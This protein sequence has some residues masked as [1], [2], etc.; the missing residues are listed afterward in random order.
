MAI[1]NIPNQ[2]IQL[3]VSPYE[4]CEDELLH[5]ALYR[6]SDGEIYAQYK[7]IP[8]ETGLVNDGTYDFNA[9]WSLAYNVAGNPV[10]THTIGAAGY[11]R[12]VFNYGAL[13]DYYKLTIRVY[14]STQGSLDITFPPYLA[15]TITT[16]GN[17]IYTMYWDYVS[18]FSP[19]DYFEILPTTDFDG[20]VEIMELDAYVKPTD[21]CFKI[22]NFKG[23]L[24]SLNPAA[25]NFSVFNEY[26]TIVIQPSWFPSNCYY[27][28][29]CNPCNP[30]ESYQSTCIQIV[31]FDEATDTKLIESHCQPNTG[32][33]NQFNFNW[34]TGFMTIKQRLKC[35]KFAPSFPID[36]KSYVFSNGDKKI[37]SAQRSK[38]YDIV[39][40]ELNETQHETLSM[41]II[42]KIFT[43]D[44]VE[45]FVEPDDYKPEWSKSTGYSLADV[46]VI[47]MTQGTIIF[48]E[49]QN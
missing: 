19:L 26:L 21:S 15:P 31:D 20:A 24:Q 36:A 41:Q 1:Q 39:F 14:G 34:I 9:D 47:G 30:S 8:C 10:F 3:N 49:N 22:Y 27:F 11:I 16:N 35:K 45:Y 5:C 48:R 7:L 42:S 40:G 46:R 4:T 23:Q 29:I 6:E 44:G 17:G 32:F 33:T 18:I 12:N 2:P 43:I 37:T 28:T 38:F 13:G 25:L